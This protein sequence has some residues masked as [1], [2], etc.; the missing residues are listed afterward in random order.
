MVSLDS[1]YSGPSQRNYIKSECLWSKTLESPLSS[2]WDIIKKIENLKVENCASKSL[3]ISCLLSTCY[4]L[5]FYSLLVTTFLLATRHESLINIFLKIFLLQ[6]EHLI[7]KD[8]ITDFFRNF[9]W[10]VGTPVL[11]PLSSQEN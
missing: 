5:L 1:L 6:P 7:K 8:S 4:F 10:V 3:P 11:H 2:W 9:V